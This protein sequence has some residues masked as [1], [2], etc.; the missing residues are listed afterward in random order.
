MSCEV[1][2]SCK[3]R[4]LKKCKRHQKERERENKLKK[5]QKDIKKRGVAG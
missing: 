5:S 3:R 1:S 4:N 2:I